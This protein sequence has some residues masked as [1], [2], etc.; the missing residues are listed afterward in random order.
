MTLELH[1][2]L[3]KQLSEIDT[4][5]LANAI[6]LS[7]IR[8]RN[9]G[10]IKE[11]VKCLTP[12]FDYALTGYA[13]TLKVRTSNPPVKGLTFED[14]EDWWALIEKIPSPRVMVI[15]DADEKPGT[16]SVAGG[17]HAAIF[18]ALGCNGII[19]N[20]CVRD[21]PLMQDMGLY[22]FAA[23]LSP[24]HAYAHIVDV[25]SPVLVGGLAISPGDLLH[26]DK[27]GVVSVPLQA[28]PTLPAL[29]EQ[30]QEEEN[31]VLRLCRTKPFDHK[32]LSNFF[33]QYK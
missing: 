23:G 2:E 33:Q 21:L 15:E 19:T 29:A 16:A 8:L 7:H 25:C 11:T 31:A 9:E 13:V 22:A 17:T 14:R 5:T 12:D 6:E 1:P 3:I 18:R 27:H 26:G 20:G 24:S 30:L 10:Y 28:V 32:A 4:P